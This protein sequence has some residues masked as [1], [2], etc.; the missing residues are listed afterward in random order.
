MLLFQTVKSIYHSTGCFPLTILHGLSKH[1]TRVSVATKI[2]TQEQAVILFK[3]WIC[4]STAT[5]QNVRLN[6]QPIKPPPLSLTVF[7][8][9]IGKS[10]QRG[11]AQLGRNKTFRSRNIAINV[12][13]VQNR[14][15]KQL[16]CLPVSRRWKINELTFPMNMH[17]NI[18]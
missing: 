5:S 13:F 11:L 3:D 14:G 18:C 9:L 2:S 4:T 8:T 17:M 6:G 12:Y 15:N 1:P 10:C 16:K 7:A